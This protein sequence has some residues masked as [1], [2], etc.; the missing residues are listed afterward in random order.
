MEIIWK[1][2]P[3][4][5]RGSD[6]GVDFFSSEQPNPNNHLAFLRGFHW[7]HEKP[8]LI[9]IQIRPADEYYS[10]DDLSTVRSTIEILLKAGN[11][12]CG[13]LSSKL[14]AYFNA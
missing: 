14:Y 13:K 7:F 1:E 9:E 5:R 8:D 3:N 10:E 11:L 2:T 4:L 12:K 6:H